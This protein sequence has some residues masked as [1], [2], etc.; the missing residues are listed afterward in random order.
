[1]K[2]RLLIGLSIVTVFS[3]VNAQSSEKKCVSHE[4]YQAYLQ[5]HPEALI[6]KENLEKATQSKKQNPNQKTAEVVYTIPVVV[7]V[8]HAGEDYGVGQ[9]ITDE[10]IMSQLDALNKDFR[11]LNTDKLDPNHPFYGLA[12]DAAIEFCLAKRDSNNVSTTGIIRYNK[13]QDGWTVADF[14]AIVKPATA[15]NRNNYMNMWTTTFTGD[16]ATTLGY[17]TFPGTNHATDGLVMAAAAFGTIGNLNVGVNDLGR[18]A[19]HEVGHYLNLSH[20]WGD[21]TCGDDLVDDTPISEKENYGCPTFPFNVSGTCSTGGNGEM[22]MNYMDYVDDACM[23]TFTIG[24]KDRMRAAIEASR[25]SLLNSLGCLTVTN[26]EKVNNVAASLYPNP[27]N[28]S[29]TIN[30]NS[31]IKRISVFSA[32]GQNVSALV[33]SSLNATNAVLNTQTLANGNYV[34]RIETANGLSNKQLVIVK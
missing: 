10:Q 17:A 11:L 15:W 23:N 24:Q 32:S 18:T 30:S 8:I 6:A 3:A 19:T 27:A 25:S 13:V 31:S 22:F 20:I 12:A 29:V 2:K 9:N 34:V 4:K 1:M 33:G 26:V 7:H 21:A 14:D 28:G 16:D 5:S